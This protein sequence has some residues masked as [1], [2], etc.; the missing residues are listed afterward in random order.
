MTPQE[1]EPPTAT[2]FASVSQITFNTE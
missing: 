1:L 2:K